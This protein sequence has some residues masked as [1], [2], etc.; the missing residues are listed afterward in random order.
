MD[1]VGYGTNTEINFPDLMGI[2]DVTVQ[3]DRM[4]PEFLAKL[5][6]SSSFRDRNHQQ[7]IRVDHAGT[8]VTN[9]TNTTYEKL[10]SQKRDS[11]KVQENCTHLQCVVQQ[12]RNAGRAH[13]L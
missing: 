4:D 10:L 7:C 13:L 6:V 8:N 5:L 12:F 9:I 11:G 1:N 3:M 2:M